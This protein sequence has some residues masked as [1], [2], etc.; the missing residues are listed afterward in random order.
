[1]MEY[2]TTTRVF[3]RSFLHAHTGFVPLYGIITRG[4]GHAHV[5]YSNRIP[6]AVAR[7]RKR[8]TR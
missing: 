6:Q 7:I 8:K 5:D 3:V 4:D 1:M 2:G